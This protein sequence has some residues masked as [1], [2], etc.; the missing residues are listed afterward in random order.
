MSSKMKLNCVIV[1]K[2]STAI[3]TIQSQGERAVTMR[4]PSRNPTGM[5]LKR[6][7]K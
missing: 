2:T 6:L 4:P 3:P 1:T 7:I 5:R